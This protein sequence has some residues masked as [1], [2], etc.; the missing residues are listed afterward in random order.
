MNLNALLPKTA[1]QYA[2]AILTLMGALIP[3]H[4]NLQFIS[5]YSGFSAE[6]FIS[7]G[8]ANPAASSLSVDL[9][10]AALVGMSFMLIEARRLRMRFAWLYLILT[11]LVAFA[12]AFPLFLYVREMYLAQNEE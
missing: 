8:F 7:E 2:L 1:F 9:G 5:L 10:I 11:C 6:H 4:F 12:C 3:W